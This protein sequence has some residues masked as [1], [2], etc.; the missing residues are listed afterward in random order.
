MADSAD[1]GASSSK[2]S[3]SDA[4]GESSESKGSDDSKDSG[5]SSSSDKSQISTNKP[6]PGPSCLTAQGA[7]QECMGDSD[8]C[9]DFYCGIDPDGSTRIKVC[10][11][12]G[13]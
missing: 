3:R 5:D 4:S 6:P 13:G 7:V 11:Y 2:S 8:C 10:L 1:D 9:R 12:G